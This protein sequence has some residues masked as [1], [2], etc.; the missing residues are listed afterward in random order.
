MVA[1]LLSLAACGGE[2]DPTAQPTTTTT[3]RSAAPVS[4]TVDWTKR[5]PPTAFGDWTVQSCEG[6]A[7]LLCLSSPEHGTGILERS[8]FP[9]SSLSYATDDE[10]ATLNA[11][12]RDFYTSFVEDRAEG[13]GK[14]YELRAIEPTEV[15]VAGQRG[16]RYGF[17]GNRPG[18]RTSERHLNHAIVDGDELVILS[19]PAYDEN[20]CVAREQEMTTAA[21]ADFEPRLGPVV[22]GMRLP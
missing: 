12:A 2:R 14:E 20:A 17:S 15:Q 16:L 3:S 5:V 18:E 4:A 11:H 9:L 19:L 7:P 6:D 22:A 13:C 1:I 21:Q 10:M 8:E